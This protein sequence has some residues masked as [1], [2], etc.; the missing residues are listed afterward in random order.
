MGNGIAMQQKNICLAARG[1][2][3]VSYHK[4]IENL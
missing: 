3:L 4:N 2:K 1:F